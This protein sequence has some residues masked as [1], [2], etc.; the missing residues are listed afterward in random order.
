[1]CSVIGEVLLIIHIIPFCPAKYVSPRL[2]RTCPFPS[3]EPGEAQIVDLLPPPHTTVVSRDCNKKKHLSFTSHILLLAS[4]QSVDFQS[5]AQTSIR[6]KLF[7]RLTATA[8]ACDDLCPRRP[9]A[10][11]QHKTPPDFY[12]HP[13]VHLTHI[14]LCKPWYGVEPHIYSCRLIES[15]VRQPAKQLQQTRQVPRHPLLSRLLLGFLPLRRRHRTTLPDRLRLEN[16]KLPNRP[17][18]SQL[19]RSRH[20]HNALR[21]TRVLQAELFPHPTHYHLRSRHRPF[22]RGRTSRLRLCQAQSEFDK[23]MSAARMLLISS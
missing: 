13:F 12:P 1:M 11:H 4:L 23:Y 22:E 16:A 2:L 6:Q 20:L 3:V 17:H 5:L 19:H 10:T 8:V 14:L 7:V 9:S 18:Q 21:D 15:L